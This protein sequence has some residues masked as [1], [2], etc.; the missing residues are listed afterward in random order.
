MLSALIVLLYASA[1]AAQTILGDWLGTLKAGPVE[2]RVVIHVRD[3]GN[4]SLTGTL[5]SLDQGAMGIPIT[6]ISS[7]GPGVKFSVD[8][9]QGAFDG[10]F[11]QEESAIEGTWTQGPGRIPL[12]LK[13]VRDPG[14]LALRRPQNPVKP[15]PYREEEVAYDNKSAGITLSATLTLPS[16]SG[17]FPAVLLVSGSGPQDRDESLLG[18]RP[19]FVL[20]DYLTRHGIA[21]LR[22]DDRGVGKSKG[23]FAAATSVD[24]A[25]DAEAGIAYLLSRAEVNKR[26]I[27]LVGHSEGGLIAPIVAAR[28]SAVAF[29]VLMAGPGVPGDEI[30]VAQSVLIAEASGVGRDQAEKNGAELR[31]TIAV[32]KREKD[33][34]AVET[35]LRELLA[36]RIPAPQL[37]AQIRALTA[38]WFRYFIE[39]DP[40]PTLRTVKC[41]VLAIAGEKDLQVPPKQNLAAI[42]TALQ[43]GGNKDV[44]VEELP[45]LNHLFQT[46]KTGSPAEYG[47]IEETISPMALDRIARWIS[48]R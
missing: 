45:G 28:N 11:N 36:G 18:H 9:I 19:F 29:I 32:V 30:L 37:D 3:G 23:N 31:Q 13:R 1:A 35:K 4:G 24:F 6:A 25:S 10:R 26:K 8:A 7:N 33:G 16:G 48:R 38:P 43:A 15:Y 47:Q 14:E 21:V 42:R 44:E 46:A 22:A 39:Y 41:A 2:L 12:V 34:A 5:D 17:P 20:A 40:A 27:G